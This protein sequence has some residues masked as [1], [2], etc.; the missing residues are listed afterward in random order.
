M[1]TTAD[2]VKIRSIAAPLVP[3]DCSMRGLE[4]MP[5]MTERLRRSRTWLRA[6]RR[7]ELG[8]YLMNLWSASWAQVPAGSL[9]DDDDV[10]AEAAMCDPD[11][12]LEVRAEVLRGWLSCSADGRLYHPVVCQIATGVWT[13][14]QE[15]RAS[16]AKARAAKARKHGRE[17]G[18]G[19]LPLPDTRRR[20]R[21]VSSPDTPTARDTFARDTDAIFH[22]PN[23]L[24][25]SV[26]NQPN[27][28]QSNES[29]GDARSATD[30]QQPFKC[31]VVSEK[32]GVDPLK[33]PQRSTRGERLADH[34]EPSQ[35]L[36][37]FAGSLN[38]DP[39]TFEAFRD[40]YRAASGIRGRSIDWDASA[41]SWCRVAA[42]RRRPSEKPSNVAWMRPYAEQR[43]AE[44]FGAVA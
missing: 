40:H 20:S 8:F 21:P 34:W 1:P 13:A 5:L 15:F 6:K 23:S 16:T 28:L 32:K 42:G 4:Y 26:D 2:S 36:Q 25:E 3:A 31:E 37:A 9:E 39:D 22:E 44:V 14:R 17:P 18:Q 35:E 11:V 33:T 7:P 24:P 41:R 27:P 29:N 43:F 19:T 30:L 12:W 38:L 10:L